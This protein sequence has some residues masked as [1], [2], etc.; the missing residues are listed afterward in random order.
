MRMKLSN[1]VWL[2]GGR[3]PRAELVNYVMTVGEKNTI[4]G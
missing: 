1:C 4:G 3:T 2:V